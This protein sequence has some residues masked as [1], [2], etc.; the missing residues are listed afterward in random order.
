MRLALPSWG[1]CYVCDDPLFCAHS[2]PSG[3]T[4][5]SWHAARA[6]R[7]PCC[8]RTRGRRPRCVPTLERISEQDCRLA[9]TVLFS[10]PMPKHMPRPGTRN[11]VPQS[12]WRRKALRLC[13][14]LLRLGIFTGVCLFAHAL[15]GRRH[16]PC[17]ARPHLTLSRVHLQAKPPCWSP[18]APLPGLTSSV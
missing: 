18:T 3:W 8:T 1:G 4:S 17:S 11:A 16:T 10:V 5:R 12:H 2:H 13:E 7:S 15:P 14:A 9:R 6:G